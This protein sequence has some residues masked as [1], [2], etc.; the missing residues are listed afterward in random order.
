M[1][2]SIDLSRILTFFDIFVRKFEKKRSDLKKKG[3]ELQ[4][5]VPPFRFW[6]YFGTKIC[7]KLEKSPLKKSLKTQPFQKSIFCCNLAFLEGKTLNFKAFW[8]AFESPG[9]SFS[10]VFW[11]CRFCLNC[12][13]FLV[14]KLIK[15][16]TRQVAFVS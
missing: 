5:G 6:S 2:F 14:K 16:K 8:D 10:D 3:F 15:A 12:G 13:A 7:Q 1:E 4:N 9:A 11:G